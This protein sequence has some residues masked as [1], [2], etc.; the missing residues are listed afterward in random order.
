MQGEPVD[1]SAPKAE[2]RHGTRSL[3]ESGVGER[4]E[5]ISERKDTED[6]AGVDEAHAAT[7]PTGITPDD[8]EQ[9]TEGLGGVH[10]IEK[11]ALQPRQMQQQIE[12]LFLHFRAPDALVAVEDADLGGHLHRQAPP[13]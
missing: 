9:A 8:V 11:D 6:A 3:P 4:A 10:G 1:L 5:R 7:E 2:F 12:L 13:A